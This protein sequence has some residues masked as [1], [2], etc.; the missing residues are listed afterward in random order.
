MCKLV[1]IQKTWK[2]VRTKVTP[3]LFFSFMAACLLYPGIFSGGRTDHPK[4]KGQGPRG[5]H[6]HALQS[7]VTLG[8][9]MIGHVVSVHIRHLAT[10]CVLQ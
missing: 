1:E 5:K 9:V 4:A 3:L 10:G 7:S 6:P 2:F 8:H